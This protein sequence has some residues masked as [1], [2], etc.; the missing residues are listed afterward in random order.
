[1]SD[2]PLRFK[3]N[4]LLV[5]SASQDDERTRLAEGTSNVVYDYQGTVSCYDMRSLVKM[6]A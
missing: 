1:M 5:G 2:F 4:M 3:S 6:T